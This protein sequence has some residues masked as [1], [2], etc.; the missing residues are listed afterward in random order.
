MF[1]QMALATSQSQT[2]TSEDGHQPVFRPPFVLRLQIDDE[3]YYQQS[4]DKVPYVS[5][6][7]V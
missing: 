7:E 4:F 5:A 3:H 1:I 6:G 2:P